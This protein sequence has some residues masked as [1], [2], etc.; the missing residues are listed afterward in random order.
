MTLERASYVLGAA[1]G[2]WYLFQCQAP[3]LSCRDESYLEFM[4][5][6]IPSLRRVYFPTF[7]APTA[8]AQIVITTLGDT[9]Y[10]IMPSPYACRDI[11]R[12]LDGNM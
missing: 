8:F 11:I 1:Y 6:H 2:I 7:W 10:T 4:R 9:F 3:E 5:K 12:M